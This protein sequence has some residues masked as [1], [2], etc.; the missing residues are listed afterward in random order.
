[1][2][3]KNI[4]AVRTWSDVSTDGQTHVSKL[5]NQNKQTIATIYLHY[6][7]A[8]DGTRENEMGK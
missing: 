6:S 3:T 4:L 8:L 2:K 7:S 5:F 1:M